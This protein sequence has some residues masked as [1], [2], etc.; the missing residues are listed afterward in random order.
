MS[1]GARKPAPLRALAAADVR[2][3]TIT[4][5]GGAGVIR[6]DGGTGMRLDD[7]LTA[8]AQLALGF[9]G[10]M[11]NDEARAAFKGLP[12]AKVVRRA[13]AALCNNTNDKE[14]PGDD[15]EEDGFVVTQDNNTKDNETLGSK[16]PKVQ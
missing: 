3:P 9:E 15:K 4:R 1:V 14:E 6:R 8:A 11:P 7:N 13:L 2:G 5:S 10:R 12:C 16:A